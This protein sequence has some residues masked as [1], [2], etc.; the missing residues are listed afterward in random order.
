MQLRSGKQV[1]NDIK[2]SN[3]ITSNNVSLKRKNES[4]EDVEPIKK[5]KIYS[6]KKEKAT[7]KEKE[8][9]EIIPNFSNDINL[10]LV[11]LNGRLRLM[12]YLKTINFTAELYETKCAIYEFLYVSDFQ[13][14]EDKALELLLTIECKL[15][16]ITGFMNFKC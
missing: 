3:I 15:N 16:H 14:N 9:K 2:Q 5:R 12:E 4:E 7:K 11:L 1:I 10:Q 13:Y 8:T 6:P